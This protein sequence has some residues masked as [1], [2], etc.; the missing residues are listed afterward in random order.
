MRTKNGTKKNKIREQGVYPI[1]NKIK[2]N[3]P[4]SNSAS[5]LFED[6]RDTP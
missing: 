3:D 5:N 2:E 6:P 1:Q 4:G